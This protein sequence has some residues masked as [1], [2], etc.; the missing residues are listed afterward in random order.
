MN[1]TKTKKLY[2]FTSFDSAVKIIQNKT[3]RYSPL[4]VMNDIYESNRPIF[5]DYKLNNPYNQIQLLEKEFAKFRQIS[6][7]QDSTNK[8]G[9][10]ISPMWGHYAEK[11]NGVCLVFDKDKIIEK[12]QNGEY[13]SL[14]SYDD[15]YTGAVI[16]DQTN[17]D[18]WFKDNHKEI[19][20]HKSNEWSYEQEYRIVKKCS[21]NDNAWE[22]VNFEDALIAVIMCYTEGVSHSQSIF[23]SKNYEELT[24]L[25][26]VPIF[27]YGCFLNDCGLKDYDGNSI[28]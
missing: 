17:I 16:C 3:L 2:H 4:K 22:F 8:M 14:I 27:E 23:C 15:E 21:S 9:F 5:V 25:T 13:F 6:L 10:A 11:G 1:F 18:S 12:L 19:F 24:R 26:N 7:T 28:W 20:F